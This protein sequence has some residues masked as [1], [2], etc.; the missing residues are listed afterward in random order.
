M[1]ISSEVSA[2][3][4][5]NLFNDMLKTGNFPNNLKVAD[6]TPVFK[7]KNPF[8]K[9]N[10]RPVS[11]SPSISKVFEKLMQKQISGYIN[12]YLSPYLCGYRKGF[13]SQQAL[14]SLIENWKRVL[15]KKGFGGAV[16][17]DLSKAFHPIKHDLITAKL[18]AYGFSKETRKLLHSYLSNRWHRT[19]ISKQFSSWQE[20]IQEEPQGSALGLLLF[21]IYL[22]DLFCIAESTKVCNFA[23]DTTF[24]ACDRDV[25]SLINR[26]EHD[27]YL[28]IE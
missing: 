16:L 23:D 5:H 15:D 19:K 2:D 20:L 18:Y 22:N 3:T 6:I 24:Y 17:M 21:N 25:S 14:M 28:T 4:L 10:Y 12:N 1:R 13:S 26:L 7:K 27:S 11:V 8:H 9:V